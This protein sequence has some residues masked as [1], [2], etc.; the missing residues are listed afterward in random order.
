[1][2]AAYDG[3]QRRLFRAYPSLKKRRSTAAYKA[4]ERKA[5]LWLKRQPAEVKILSAAYDQYGEAAY[6]DEVR[7][8]QL[9]RFLR[10]GRTLALEGQ[11]AQTGTPA[12]KSVFARLRRAEGRNPLRP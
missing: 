12:Q 3:L 7:E 8:A 6:A 11:L 4:A 2:S 10:M 1:V 5:I 9:W